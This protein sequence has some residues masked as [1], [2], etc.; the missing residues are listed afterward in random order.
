MKLYYIEIQHP[1]HDPAIEDAEF[2]TMPDKSIYESNDERAWKHMAIDMAS[3]F[4]GYNNYY[5]TE[6]TFRF[7][8]EDKMLIGDFEVETEVIPS[9]S[10][11]KI[12]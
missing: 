5:F 9:F 4:H 2:C 10:A 1:G 3:E 6:I 11:R 12:K 7:W 8:R